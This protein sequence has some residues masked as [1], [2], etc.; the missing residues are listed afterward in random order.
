MFIL[1]SGLRIALTLDKQQQPTHLLD[2]IHNIY[3]YKYMHVYKQERERHCY[4]L[5]CKSKLRSLMREDNFNN[6]SKKHD[7]STLRS[8]MPQI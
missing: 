5:Q 2:I 6:A 7:T 8:I 4:Y 3:L 1:S